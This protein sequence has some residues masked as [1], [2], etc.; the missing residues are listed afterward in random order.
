MAHENKYPTAARFILADDV[1]HEANQ[2]IS[3]IGAYTGNEI[4]ITPHQQIPAGQT[5]G[6]PLS[7]LVVLEGGKGV[8]KGELSVL[9]PKQT[10]LGAASIE[11][12]FGGAHTMNLVFRFPIVPFAEAGRYTAELTFDGSS[13]EP[14]RYS[15]NVIF[16]QPKIEETK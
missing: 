10:P 9:S 1:R 2:K 3:I 7:L 13:A 12:D 5:L 6:I 16:N 4:T 14:Y 15:F 11:F 8:I